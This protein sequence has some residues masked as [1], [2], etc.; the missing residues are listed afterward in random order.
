M[1]DLYALTNYT[2]CVVSSSSGL[3]HNHSC[4]TICLPQP[5]GPPGPVPSPS[6]ATRY[7]VAVLGCLFGMVVALGAVYYCR[8]R[9]RHRGATGAQ[10]CGDTEPRGPSCSGGG[11]RSLLLPGSFPAWPGEQSRVLS[12]NGRGGWTPLRPLRG[13]QETRVALRG[14]VI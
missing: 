12:P 14:K 4:L 6:T 5:P 3:H 13:L 10:S 9:R 8:R 1:A 11:T 2:Y 7:I